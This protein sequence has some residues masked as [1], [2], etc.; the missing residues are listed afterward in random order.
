MNKRLLTLDDLYDFY[1][2]KKKSMTFSAEK[3]GEPLVFQVSGNLTFEENDDPTLAGLCPVRLQACHTETNLN[4][5]TISYETMENKLLPTFK[6]RP[7]LGFIHDVDGKPQFYTHNAHEEDGEIVYDEIAVGNVPETNNAELVY[8]E[9]NDRY[10]VFIDGYV[11]DEYTKASEI[12]QREGECPCSVE[13]SVK[14]MTWDN[15]DKTL[16]IEDGYFSGVTILGY[17]ENG[18]KVMPGM[19]GSNVKLKDFSQS[20]N[21]V[22]NDLPESEQSKLIET[23]EALNKTLSSLNIDTFNKEDFEK[24]GSTEKNM[25]FEELLSKYNKTV[26]D[27]TFEY[28]SLMD[29]ELEAKFE[30]EFGTDEPEADPEDPEGSSEPE[31]DPEEPEEP[32]SP[33]AD[34]EPENG[35]ESFSKVFSLSHEDLRS[36]LYRLLEPIEMAE[37]D[38]YWIVSTYDNHFIYESYMGNYFKQKFTTT[39]DVVA[40]DG[41]REPVFAEFVTE[42]ELAELNSMRANYS[43]IQEKLAKYEEAEDIADKM[44]VF[45]DEAYGEYLETDE[46]KALMKKDV[47]TKFSKEELIEKADAAL[48]KLVKTHKTFAMNTEPEVKNKP[49]VL[50]FVK[51][52]H[53]SSFLDGL[54]KQK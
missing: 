41:D 38:C 40:F 7:I 3:N 33:E 48:G 28:D 8:D 51:T 26:E 23:L 54:L 29:E 43:S 10:N 31:G 30:E 46:F 21:S 16:H 25:K 12:I 2:K 27:I 47:L 50:P 32:E 49:T 13:I 15:K 11:Y 6:N 39:D 45:E 44:T 20:N 14:Q 22:V 5:S 52:E 18:N 35:T 9:E 4:R 37:N 17:D 1:S 42:A 34:P 36:S 19:T 53:N 24:G